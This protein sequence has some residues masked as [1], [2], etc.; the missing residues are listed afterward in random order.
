M[1]RDGF[2]LHSLGT[3]LNPERVHAWYKDLQG[4]AGYEYDNAIRAGA[5]PKAISFKTFKT[6]KMKLADA[7]FTARPNAQA[8]RAISVGEWLRLP[9]IVVLSSGFRF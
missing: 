4:T 6:V 3:I 1:N 9:L 5:L 8:I 2:F 7:S